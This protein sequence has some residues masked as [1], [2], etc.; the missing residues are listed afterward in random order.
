M[1]NCRELP[2]LAIMLASYASGLPRAI[3]VSTIPEVAAGVHGYPYATFVIDVCYARDPGN[4]QRLAETL[5]PLRPRLR[6]ATE[7]SPFPWNVKTLHHGLN[8]ALQTDWGPIDLLGE[9]AGVGGYQEARAASLTV[10]LCGVQCSVLTLDAL[11]ASKRASGRDKD[12]A[13]V[14]ELEAIREATQG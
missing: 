5:A 3:P 8:F 14:K 10:S 6:G 7:H 12:L 1:A 13:V 2:N 9:I 11:I 4:L